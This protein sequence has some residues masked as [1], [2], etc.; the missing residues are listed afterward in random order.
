MKSAARVLPYDSILLACVADFARYER[1]R[2]IHV[3]VYAC[4]RRA[5]RVR[6]LD[7]AMR[8]LHVQISW[9]A[10]GP[11][12]RLDLSVAHVRY[13]RCVKKKRSVRQL[14][15][16]SEPK[17]IRS[18]KAKAEASGMTIKQWVEHSLDA[19]PVLTT[20]VRPATPTQDAGG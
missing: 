11:P 2:E 10:R 17:R 8:D 4:A 14:I 15:V 13:R 19:A 12:V 3:R 7:R 5:M 9:A 18:W 6:D 20:T 1:S 16:E